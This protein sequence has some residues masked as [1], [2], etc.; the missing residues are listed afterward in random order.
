MPHSAGLETVSREEA[1]KSLRCLKIILD[2]AVED[3]M[4]SALQALISSIWQRS[5]AER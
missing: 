4:I 5:A 2:Q 1:N 3:E